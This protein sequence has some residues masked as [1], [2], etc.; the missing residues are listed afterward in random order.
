MT[1]IKSR[2]RLFHLGTENQ[3]M[4]FDGK[5]RSHHN[6]VNSGHRELK[7]LCVIIIF[8]NVNIF[9]NF[10]LKNPWLALFLRIT[11]LKIYMGVD[12]SILV[13]VTKIS[14]FEGLQLLACL[15]KWQKVNCS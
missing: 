14:D 1:S 7:I 3:K 9:Y 8:Q 12:F 2:A 6:S 11:I 13:N 4:A 15:F 10:C 5:T